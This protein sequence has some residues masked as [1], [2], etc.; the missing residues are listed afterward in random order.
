MIPNWADCYEAVADTKCVLNVVG[1]TAAYNVTR[2]SVSTVSVLHVICF[3][4]VFV[5]IPPNPT[6]RPMMSSGK[7]ANWLIAYYG[8]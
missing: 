8:S 2:Y 3:F 7:R 4:G 1:S 6:I 5:F